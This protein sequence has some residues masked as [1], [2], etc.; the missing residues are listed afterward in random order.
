MVCAMSFCA[1]AGTQ[2][3]DIDPSQFDGQTVALTT[4]SMFIPVVEE[5]IKDPKMMYYSTQVDCVT[6]VLEGKADVAVSDSPMYEYLHS[7]IPESKIGYIGDEVNSLA[8]AAGKGEKGQRLIDDFNR[9]LRAYDADGRLDKLKEKWTSGPEEGRVMQSYK[10]LPATNGVLR[11]A[12]SAGSPPFEYI[13]NGEI[14]GY[15]IE[16]IS[17]YCKEAGLGLDIDNMDFSTV[18]PGI[19]TGK[20]DMAASDLT[21]TEE[22]KESVLFSDPVMYSRFAAFYVDKDATGGTAG[23]QE[24]TPEDFAGKKIGVV[25]GTQYAAN[26]SKYIKDPQPYYFSTVPDTI[27]A[28]QEGKIDGAMEESS[29]LL[30]M[31]SA[32]KD[33][34]VIKLA[35]ETTYTAEIA[36]KTEKGERLIKEFN[37]TLAR[38]KENGEYDRIFDKWMKEDGGD[39][40]EDY[41]K[42][43]DINGT[44]VIATEAGLPP[45]NFV[46]D[47]VLAGFEVDLVGEFCKEHGYKPDFRSVA[48]DGIIAGLTSGKYDMGSSGFVITEERKEKLLFSDPI[49]ENYPALAYIEKGEDKTVV[50][51]FNSIKNSFRKTFIEEDRWKMFLEGIGVTLFITVFSII[52]GCILGFAVHLICRTG[53]KVTN[54]ISNFCRWLIQGMPEVVFLM[55]LFYIVFGKSSID[56][57]WVATIGFTVLFACFIHGMLC[58]GEAAID[59]GQYQATTALGY[60]DLQSFFLIILPQ[61]LKYC[62]PSLMTQITT[63]L[64]ATAV[65]GYIAVI[66][67]TKVGDLIRGRTYDAFFPLIA[68]AVIYFILAALLKLIMRIIVRRLD[69]TARTEEEIK[70]GLVIE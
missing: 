16:L 21:I 61:A 7:M 47:G 57:M 40:L 39:T 8:F 54:A 35:D 28:L 66:D 24:R 55:V 46:K 9:F 48:F 59:K 23:S 70:K 4:G 3:E 49:M 27:T 52:G 11:V 25:S 38:L 13:S 53:N 32:I 65:V 58:S 31:T 43:P 60:S 17:E 1:Y 34:H 18:L 36:T 10:E 26:M 29:I 51:F 20:Y 67:V 64:K 41:S 56:G 12:T 30:Y 63:H 37:E 15:D 69:T 14:V 19:A 5:Y 45:F 50:S 22:R 2:T 6:A 62:M 33:A 68:V 44:I 42:L